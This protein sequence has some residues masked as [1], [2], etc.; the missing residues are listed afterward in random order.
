MILV[1]VAFNNIQ[2]NWKNIH[3]EPSISIVYVR[4]NF[5][6]LGLYLDLYEN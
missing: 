1:Y 4:E 6:L 2:S 5:G 3:L